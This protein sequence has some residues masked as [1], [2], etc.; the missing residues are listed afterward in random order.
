MEI[1]SART[2]P[3]KPGLLVLRLEIQVFPI[4]NISFQKFISEIYNQM[5]HFSEMTPMWWPFGITVLSQD[6]EA[7]GS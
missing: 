6:G 3:E 2:Y 4:N 1:E 7:Q 5:K